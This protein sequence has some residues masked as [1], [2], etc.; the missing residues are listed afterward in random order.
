M[1]LW[2]IMEGLEMAR[3]ITLNNNNASITIFGDLQK[4]IIAI[5]QL[6]FST[7]SPYLRNPIYQRNLD[8]GSN[9]HFLTIRWISG[10]VGFIGNDKPTKVPKIKLVKEKNRWS[11][12]VPSLISRKS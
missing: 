9:N 7:S 8:L 4:A 6:F 3:K 12:G 5:Q 10:H 2:A 11:N 1:E